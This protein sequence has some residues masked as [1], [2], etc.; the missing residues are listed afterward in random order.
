MAQFSQR[1]YS[2]LKRVK[3]VAAIPCFNTEKYI[4]DVVTT[5]RKYVDDV[6][7]IDDGSTDMTA[8][9]AEI[10]GACVIRHEKNR[11]KGAAI[12]TALDNAKFSNIIV[13]I[14]G[15][16][17]HDAHDIPKLL[18]PILQ[19]KADFVIGSRYLS[20]SKD[21]SNTFSRRMTNNVASFTISFI[22]SYIQPF[23][24]FVKNRSLRKPSMIN[25][26]R[27]QMQSVDKSIS[28]VQN[29]RL[30]NGKFKRI[31]DCTSGFTAMKTENWGQL[32]LISNGFQIEI[33][34]I[35]EQAK[36]GFIIAE[37]PVSCKWKVGSSNL[38]IIRDGFKTLGLLIGKLITFS[39][40]KKQSGL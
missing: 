15:D 26:P 35:Y 40:N 17:Q 10:A 25:N 8:K 20:K 3:V 6:I 18:E 32:D 27:S 21:L 16:G 37:T 13:F 23:A 24:Y 29:Y 4:T 7:V 1:N 28:G 12:K 22:I 2:T 31:S 38:S 11:G 19:E 39:D 33:E 30:V 14:D 5:A 34:M 36:N 9:T